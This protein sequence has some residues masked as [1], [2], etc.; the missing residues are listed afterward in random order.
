MTSLHVDN[1][2]RAQAERT[3]QHSKTA[4]IL[5]C[6]HT[7]D[8]HEKATANPNIKNARVGKVKI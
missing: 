5:A 6:A 3:A 2:T 4:M 7:H 1:G 8:T